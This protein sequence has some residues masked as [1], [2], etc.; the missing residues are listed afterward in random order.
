MQ[1]AGALPEGTQGH[2]RSI[3]T[4]EHLRVMGSEGTIYAMG[5]GATIY[6]V[7][8]CCFPCTACALLSA[9]K[10]GRQEAP[11]VACHDGPYLATMW[12]ARSC[13]LISYRLV[14]PQRSYPKVARLVANTNTDHTLYLR[15]SQSRWTKRRSCSTT[16]TLTMMAS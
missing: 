13:T 10:P 4:D 3:L 7:C 15:R 5:D 8:A 1:L 16:R 11:G 6:Q 2:F 9:Y 12:C 14:L